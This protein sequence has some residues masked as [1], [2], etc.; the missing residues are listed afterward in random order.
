M[1]DSNCSLEEHIALICGPIYSQEQIDQINARCK[2]TLRRRERVAEFQ[3]TEQ[4]TQPLSA[5][6]P[7]P[8]L[9]MVG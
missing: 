3:E 6:I 8:T 4:I 2:T 5:Q 7:A 9:E 1:N